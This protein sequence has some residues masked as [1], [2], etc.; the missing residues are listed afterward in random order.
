MKQKDK[1]SVVGKVGLVTSHILAL[2]LISWYL[3]IYVGVVQYNEADMFG[4]ILLLAHPIS[5][6]ILIFQIF[7]QLGR[8]NWNK[9]LIWGCMV[10]GSIA[11]VSGIA[12]IQVILF[13]SSLGGASLGST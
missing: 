1:I 4:V 5:G 10:S 9:L 2:I 12:W 3:L 8:S 11:V 6:L 13:F 7:D